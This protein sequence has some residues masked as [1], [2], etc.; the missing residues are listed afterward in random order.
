[1]CLSVAHV[2]KKVYYVLIFA[3]LIREQVKTMRRN[4][5]SLRLD[6]EDDLDGFTCGTCG[7]V[8]HKPLLATVSSSGNVR[9]Y[10]ACPRCMVKVS[11]AKPERS[12][13][14]RETGN[15]IETLERRVESSAEGSECGHFLGYLKK[16]SK[17][18]PIPDGCLTCI[19]MI[20]CLTH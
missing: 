3:I 7:E 15:A 19:K 14:E 5:D 20:E 9:T 18:A 16:R 12:A 10:F 11:S 1:M 8:F 2:F 4:V 17:D 6:A 13:S